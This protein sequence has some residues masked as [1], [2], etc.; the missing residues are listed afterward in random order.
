MPPKLTPKDFDP[1]PIPSIG[2]RRKDR[3]HLAAGRAIHQWEVVEHHFGSLFGTLLGAS[4]PVGALRAYGAMSAFNMRQ[5]LLL[6]AA[7]ALFHY[8]PNDALLAECTGIVRKIGDRAAARRSE[9]A[10]GLVIEEHREDGIHCFLVPSYHSARKRGLDDAPAYQ[11]TSKEIEEFR[12]KFAR[13]AGDVHRLN[14]AILDWHASL[15]RK[16]RAPRKP[17]T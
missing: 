12:R 11:Y 7:D 5:Q 3:V 8:N 4:V 17:P 14:V 1:T 15:P 2:D 9:I 10:H 16:P 6:H 13:L